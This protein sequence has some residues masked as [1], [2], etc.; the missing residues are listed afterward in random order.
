MEKR[1]E[2]TYFWERQQMCDIVLLF[3][4]EQRIIHERLEGMI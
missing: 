3:Q 1:G 4:R 2:R